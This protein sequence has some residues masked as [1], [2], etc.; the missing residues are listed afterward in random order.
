MMDRKDSAPTPSGELDA[1]LL[2]DTLDSLLES[3]ESVDKLRTFILELAMRGKLGTQN[4]ADIP[5][6]SV[7]EQ[8]QSSKSKK[9]SK[10]RNHSAESESK[11]NFPLPDKWQWVPALFPVEILSDR[12]KKIQTKTILEE[13]KYPVVD[14]GKVFIRGYCNDADRVIKVT[15]PIIVFGDHTRETKFIDFDFVV[16]ADGVKLLQPIQIDPR[17]YYLSLS[18]LPL[19]SRGYGRHFKLLRE[20]EIPLPPLA[21]QKRI[22]AKVDELMGLCDRLEAEQAERQT[23]HAALSRAA[24]A[25]FADEPTVENLRFLFHESFDI[26]PD[27]IRKAILSLGMRGQLVPQESQEGTGQELLVKVNGQRDQLACEQGIRLPK[28]RPP[29]SNSDMP[30]ELPESW[31]WERIGNLASHVDYGTSQKADGDTSKVPVYRMGNIADGKLSSA[32]M[33]YVPA[34]IDDL[35]RLFLHT[36]DL[37]FNRTNSYELVGKTGIFKGPSEKSTF[38]SYLIRIRFPESVLLSEFFTLA[39]NAPYFRETQIEPEIVQQCGQANFNGTKLSNTVV[40]VP[41]LKEQE[42]IVAKIAQLMTLVDD[43]EQQLTES[44]SKAEQ[45]MEAVVADLVRQN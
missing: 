44:Q 14:Q 16:G 35:P 42:R 28:K 8:I 11:T 25:R 9:S 6:L 17:F 2:I 19:G 3:N 38:A 18:W 26:S 20:S 31:A 13:G 15:S 45:L 12:G 10:T 36:N 4:D 41:P 27:G 32:N 33:K 23:L 30:Y 22:V 5:A 37:L 34:N 24:L 39:M 21:E 29:V 7:I 1:I 43:L 40:P